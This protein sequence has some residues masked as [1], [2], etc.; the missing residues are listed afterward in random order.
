VLDEYISMLRIELGS[1][2]ATD[3]PCIFSEE[4]KLDSWIVPHYLLCLGAELH[5]LVFRD[6]AILKCCLL[7]EIVL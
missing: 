5:N 4:Q 2:R 6:N 3:L 1:L 7:D